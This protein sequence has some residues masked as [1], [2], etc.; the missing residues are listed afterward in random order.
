MNVLSWIE[1]SKKALAANLRVLRSVV[2]QDVILALVVKA[3]AYGHG[4]LGVS[5]ILTKHG[6]DWLC[7][8]SLEEAEALRKSGLRK[9]ILIMGYVKRNLLARAIQLRARMFVYDQKT[10]KLLSKIAKKL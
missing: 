10:A 2:G 1:V 4:I 8:A 3:N 6:A 5:E 7:V 9:P